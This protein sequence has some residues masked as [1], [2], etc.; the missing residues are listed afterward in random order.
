V[1]AVLLSGR[2]LILG[3]ALEVSDAFVAAWLPGTEGQGVA[4]VLF[5]EY[6]PTG[7]LSRAWPRAI[8]PASAQMNP[9]SESLFPIGFGLP[10]VEDGVPASSAVK[11]ASD[12]PK[13]DWYAVLD[14]AG[15]IICF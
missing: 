15:Q 10:F 4:D 9:K 5:G 13:F 7:R 12:P 14:P 1:A 2:P 11:T 3:E 6:K 8:E